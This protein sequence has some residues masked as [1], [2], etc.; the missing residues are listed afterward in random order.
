MSPSK[1]KNK[2]SGFERDAV[3]LL[4]G[5]IKNSRFRRIPGSGAIGTIMIEP[6]L[7]ADISGTVEGF[8]KTFKIEAKVGYNSST[9][10][11]IKQF[12]L[13]KEWLDKVKMQAENNYSFPALIGKFGNVRSGVSTFVVLDLEEFAYLVNQITELQTMLNEQA[14]LIVSDM[15]KT[16]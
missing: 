9:N 10:K 7:T 5:K 16:R 13:K 6:L 15:E 11:E 1:S 12:T 2:G 14:H 8:P 3:N 4:N